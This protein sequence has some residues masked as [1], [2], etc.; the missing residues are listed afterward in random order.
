MEKE[1]VDAVMNSC[2]N[3]SFRKGKESNKTDRS[4]G[5]RE[6]LSVTIFYTTPSPA[7]LF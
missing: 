2:P 1:V 4:L 3:Y 6:I 7:I 5:W